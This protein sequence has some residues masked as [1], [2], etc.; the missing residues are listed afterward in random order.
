[1]T[2]LAAHEAF[3]NMPPAEA[4]ALLPPELV[5]ETPESIDVTPA[6]LVAAVIVSGRL[7][8]CQD[9]PDLIEAVEHFR[10]LLSAGIASLDEWA[11]E[12]EEVVDQ[13][14]RWGDRM[15]MQAQAN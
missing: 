1:M 3:A 2:P 6:L 10:T 12:A 4:R 9:V 14:I 8:D 7:G 5:I 11:E 13:V 15:T